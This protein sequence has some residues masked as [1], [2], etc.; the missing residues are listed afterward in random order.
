MHEIDYLIHRRE[1]LALTELLMWEEDN[2]LSSHFRGDDWACSS[3]RF[4]AGYCSAPHA[5][6]S[7]I[8]LRV[9]MRNH[10]CVCK[11]SDLEYKGMLSL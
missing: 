11:A 2:N 1:V 4:C 3:D 10:I 7:F 9:P 6:V 5:Q 8:M